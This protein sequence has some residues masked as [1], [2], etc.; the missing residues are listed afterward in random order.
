M[1]QEDRAGGTRP[2]T[3]IVIAGGGF[4]GLWTAGHLE[5]LL[6]GRPDVE[7]VVLC[8]DNYFLMTP[9]LF[10]ACSGVLD[11][12]HCSLPVREFLR[13]V[14][15]VEATVQ[16]VDLDRRVVHATA[17]EGAAYEVPYD[18]LVL[19][20]GGITNQGLIAGS[21][22]AF[23]FKTLADAMVL[24][25]HF[26]ERFERAD[27]ETD[28]ERKRRLLTFVVI[29]GGLVG[30][31]LFGELT[32]FADEI[33]RYYPGID[34]S[35]VRFFLF[36]RGPRILPEIEEKLAAYAT[37]VLAGRRGASLR[38]GTIVR[39]LEPG[40]VN[41]EGETIEADTIVLSAGIVA[42]PTLAGLDL[43]KD[44]RGNV[45]VDA[46]MRVAARPEVWALG[47]CARIPDPQGK[48]YPWLAQHALREGRVLA[49]NL[50]AALEGRPLQPFV[51][52]TLGIMASLGHGKG[53]GKV[54]GV[55]LYG[56][57]AWWAR[58]TYYLIQMPRFSRRLRIVIDWTSALL[59]RPDI[60][61][62]DLAS[63]RALLL[64]DQAAG[65]GEG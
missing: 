27:A 6:G 55:P 1:R 11:F 60:V 42:S 20:L 16:K 21:E 7:I 4:G 18:Q 9:L 64:R 36:E 33:V 8:R 10:E 48:P 52:E 54:L 38:P 23:T 24:R 30:V 51:Y 41:L 50:K 39:S 56:F 46:T 25:N 63:E 59:F 34:R 40:R 53:L 13:K 49:R 31:E 2:A 3:R 19:A 43:E 28:P 17:A 61:K 35:E 29:G 65:A 57:L 32:A 12:R 45:V 62:V 5:R 22:H 15:F 58:R 37:R 47:D 14:R 26:I 44:R